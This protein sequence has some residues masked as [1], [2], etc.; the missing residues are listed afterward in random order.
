MGGHLLIG[1]NIFNLDLII[2]LIDVIFS[3]FFQGVP[4]MIGSNVYFPY[5]HMNIYDNQIHFLNH[6]H[7]Y[8]LLS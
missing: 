3:E 8:W 4:R 5:F 6:T 1:S 2:F 7:L